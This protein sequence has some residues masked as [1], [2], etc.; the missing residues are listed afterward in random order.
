MKTAQS[1][2]RFVVRL[3]GLAPLA[4][5]VVSGCGDATGPQAAASTS[6]R[7]AKTVDVAATCRSLCDR[8]TACGL[9][10]A[11]KLARTTPDERSELTRMKGEAATDAAKCAEECAAEKVDDHESGPLA[12]AGRCVEQTTCDTFRSCLE[13]HADPFDGDDR[14]R[15]ASRR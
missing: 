8:A 5:A 4:V 2:G 7:P 6:A 12:I 14:S 15:E 11:E 9:E 3:L 13:Q 10:A 1:A